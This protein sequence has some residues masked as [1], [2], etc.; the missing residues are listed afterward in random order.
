MDENL[1]DYRLSENIILIMASPIKRLI[2][3]IY[4]IFFFIFIIAALYM[5]N[6]PIVQIILNAWWWLIIV[7][8]L[9]FVC[10]EIIMNGKS[11]GK[12]FTNTRVVTEYGYKPEI[13]VFVIRAIG[14]MFPLSAVSL[15]S[16]K[17][18]TF[19]D[20]FSKTFVIDEKL[21]TL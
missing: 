6:F 18:R 20:I 2:N 16:G 1:L 10:I 13:S 17:K 8:A 19:F 14:R 3:W 21:S 4:D 15:L 7:C 11:V 9:Y 5:I 12:Y